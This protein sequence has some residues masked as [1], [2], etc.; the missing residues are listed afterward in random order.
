MSTILIVEAKIKPEKIDDVKPVFEELLP[1]TRNF[2]GCEGINVCFD[3]DD[4][5]KLVLVEKWVSKER[6]EKYHHWRVETGTLQKLRELLDGPP[7]RTF[8]EIVDV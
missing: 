2:D 7:S 3:Q 8:L 4:S 6:Y 5:N 1:D